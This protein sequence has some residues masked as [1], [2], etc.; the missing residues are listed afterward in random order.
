MKKSILLFICSIFSLSTLFS[1]TF[2]IIPEQPQV[3]TTISIKYDPTGTDL[4]GQ[5]IFAI[6]YTLELGKSP[7]AHDV[8]LNKSDKSY[9]ANFQVPSNTQ[10]VFFKFTNKDGKKVDTNNEEGYHTMIYEGDKPVKHAYVMTSTIYGKN[11][12]LLGLKLQADKAVKAFEM[13]I[14]NPSE[15]FSDDYLR[16][17][18]I[19]SR[20]A[21]DAKG[22]AA[23]L[24]HINAIV[25]KDQLSEEELKSLANTARIVEGQD[26]YKSMI[27]KLKTEFPEGTHAVTAK[28]AN[29]RK[30]KNLE[31]QVKAYQEAYANHNR[32]ENFELLL[33]NMERSIATK[34]GQEGDFEN[35][36]KYAERLSGVKSKASI[37]NRFAWECTGDSIEGEGHRIKE[38]LEM[39]KRSLKLIENDMKTLED[40]LPAY[41]AREWKQGLENYYASYADTYALLAYKNNDAGTALKYQKIACENNNLEDV[42]L[43]ARYAVYIEKGQGKKEAMAFLEDVIAKGY[44]D[45]KMKQHFTKLFKENVSVE[46]A[47]DMY[48]AQLE[49]QAKAYKIKKLKEDMINKKSPDFALKN[50]EGELVSLESLKGKVVII[51]FW[52]TWCGPCK[53]SFPAMQKAV[54]KYETAD[55]VEFVFIDTWERSETKNKN[56]QKFIEDNAYTF[57]V[58]MD[59]D[60]EM[61][62]DFGVNGIPA[63]F[64]LDAKGNI[65]YSG[66]GFGG[67]DEALVDEISTIV[68]ILREGE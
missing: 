10:A 9:T 26:L 64:I 1:S 17:Y 38:G 49:Q 6:A 59:N 24:E 15:R 23:V 63:K 3:G 29:F 54:E 4:Q 37:Y 45:E 56:A 35:L 18:A 68:E 67:G 34:Y 58:L 65:R 40:K 25:A 62:G 44:A 52:A 28:Y 2:H 36:Y 53:A 11:A 21:E 7:K 33:D 39:S 60:N 13:G 19:I 32:D 47:S 57:N 46:Q 55:D 61:V 5:E 41:S 43:N 31:D 66:S 14:T 12:D 22:K 48:L 16:D 30:M 42:D 8:I 20:I 27:E 50:L 51:D